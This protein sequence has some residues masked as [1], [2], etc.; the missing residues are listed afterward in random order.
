MV[1]ILMIQSCSLIS[2]ELS[3]DS[4]YV[5]C[6]KKNERPCSVQLFGLCEFSRSWEML[7]SPKETVADLL[8]KHLLFGC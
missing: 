6:G 1:M 2:L 8:P 3:E 7:L 4:M 5:L